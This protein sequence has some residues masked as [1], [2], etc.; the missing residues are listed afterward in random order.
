MQNNIDASVT[1]SI[2]SNYLNGEVFLNMFQITADLSELDT[3][4]RES[5][6]AFILSF[7]RKNN[8]DSRVI[9]NEDPVIFTGLVA[10]S[11]E[12]DELSPESA[13][14]TA[15]PVLVPDPTQA[16]TFIAP[17]AAAL[18]ALPTNGAAVLDKNGLPWD[19][20]I[21][22]GSR[23]K[24]ADGSWRTKRGVDE[25]LLANVTSELKALM[26][27]PTA[28]SAVPAPA[29]IADTPAAVVADRSA[30]VKLLTKAS[31]VITAGKLS[32]EELNSAV[33][34]VGVPSLPLL[35]HRFDLVPQVETLI[36][37]MTAGR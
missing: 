35:A 25:T 9:G 21:H 18:P 30:F 10:H 3:E 2:E 33:I 20:R 8:E 26:G 23:T 27:I 22:A 13:F 14:A 1:L 19:D 34:S 4:Q 7:P 5:L 32:Q 37:A 31:A 11:E 15:G 12:E 29:P 17:V 16:A 6:A 28:V 36:D 24:N